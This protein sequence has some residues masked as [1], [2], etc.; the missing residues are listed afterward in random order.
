MPGRFGW[1]GCGL[2]LGLGFACGDAAPGDPGARAGEGGQEPST[3]GAGGKRSAVAGGP[4]RGGSGA[5]STEGGG[6]SGGGAAGGNGVHPPAIVTGQ[7]CSGEPFEL[8]G[9]IVR[10]CVLALSCLGPDGGA[11][12]ACIQHW[13]TFATYHLDVLGAGL[14]DRPLQFW[15]QLEPCVE[16]PLDSCQDVLACSGRRMVVDECEGALTT[17]CEGELA[18]DCATNEV[19][20]CEQ[21]TGE[22]G[23]CRELDGGVACLVL[24]ACTAPEGVETCD[25]DLAYRCRDGVGYG[26]DCSRRGMTCAMTAGFALCRERELPDATC[27]NLG[28]TACADDVMTY[29]D[30]DG[31]LFEHDCAQADLGCSAQQPVDEEHDPPWLDCVVGGCAPNYSAAD[32]CDGDDLRLGLL[33][34]GEAAVR[35]HCPDYGFATCKLDRC[36]N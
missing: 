19:V 34:N 15:T 12:S 33:M 11:I 24:P 32:S 23:R 2:V 8:D 7:D 1:L 27:T 4:A 5:S 9:E 6:E 25:G 21:I 13:P 26:V 10:R 22:K 18:I 29:C 28:E 20:D 36:A 3:S 35:V 14:L 16:A 31:V 17:R 30:A